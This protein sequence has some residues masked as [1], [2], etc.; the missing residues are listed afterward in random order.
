VDQARS[1]SV[2]EV[3]RKRRLGFDQNRNRHCHP[4]RDLLP[5]AP[6]MVRLVLFDIDGTLIRSGGA[7]EKAFARVAE[8][9]FGVPNGTARLHFAGRTDPSIVRDFFQQHGLPASPENFQR[10]FGRYL[11]YL[12][13]LLHQLEGQVLPGVHAMLEE[14]KTLAEPPM[15]GLLTG[16]VRLGAQLKLTRYQLWQHFRTGGFGD[17]SEDRNQIAVVAR[18]RGNLL[19]GRPLRGEEILVIGDTPRDIEC[20]RA[21]D[22]RVLAVA[23]GGYSLEQLRKESP[24]W[25]VQTLEALSVGEICGR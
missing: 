20:S 23:T 12:D 15:L 24:T 13:Q 16:N 11:F 6:I 8:A 2:V 18:D 10:F 19:M 9:E 3:R 22:A 21:I 25:S 5:F 17:D 1:N 4:G 7:G 14:L